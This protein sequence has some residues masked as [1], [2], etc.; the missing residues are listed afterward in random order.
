MLVHGTAGAYDQAADA[1]KLVVDHARAA[2]DARL[3]TRGAIGYAVSALHGPTPATEAIRRC[4]QLAIDVAGDRKAEA[5]IFGVLAQLH[6]MRGE[7]EQGRTLYGKARSMLDDLGPS[8][9][10]ASTS[11]E[12]SRV[13]VL[14]GDL[15]A[16]ERELRRDHAALSELGEQYYLSTVAALLA[17]V[18][19]ARGELGEAEA[20]SRS[21]EELADAD[22]VFSQVAWRGAR[23]RILALSGH[24]DEAER[25]ATEAVVMAAE[26]VDISLHGDA[27]LDLGVVLRRTGRD[28]EAETA[29]NAAVELYE[30]KEDVVSAARA[31][32]LLA[33]PV[34]T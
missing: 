31:R 18:L 5:V 14:A 20:L 30:L 17:G 25:L 3:A 7:F 15:A 32:A 26:T 27:L 28:D 33:D 9:T 34:R 10:A 8:V 24:P 11:T 6:A 19:E 22:D 2:G 12:S 13:E 23:A 29:W 21:A 1:A 4:E 16:A